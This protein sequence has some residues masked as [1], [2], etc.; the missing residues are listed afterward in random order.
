MS[1]IKKYRHSVR[2]QKR[3]AKTIINI[4][5]GRQLLIYDFNLEADFNIVN[6]I[7][8]FDKGKYRFYS[9]GNYEN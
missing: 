6:L 1:D 9:G 8:I 5:K 4:K 2:K 7:I 3:R